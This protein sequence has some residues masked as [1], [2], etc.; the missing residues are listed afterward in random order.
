[1]KRVCNIRCRY[2][3]S[4]SD[5]NIGFILYIAHG[6][7]AVGRYLL[8]LY[9]IR[10]L[11]S[12]SLIG[13]YMYRINSGFIINMPITL[14]VVTC[15]LHRLS[16]FVILFYQIICQYIFIS[17]KQFSKRRTNL[18]LSRVDSYFSVKNI[19]YIY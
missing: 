11:H 19:V 6:I 10:F 12:L 1:M 2:Q 7:R 18:L 4:H 3:T 9:Q 5:K 16:Y 17:N 13:T 15:Y 14:C 8:V